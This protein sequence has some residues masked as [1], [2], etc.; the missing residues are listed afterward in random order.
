M[1]LQNSLM[2]RIRVSVEWTCERIV[3]AAK[4]AIFSRTQMLQNS[5]LTKYYTVAVLLANCRTCF[6]GGIDTAYFGVVPPSIDDYS[7]Q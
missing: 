7:N 3:T 5:P 4:F 2:S 1:V 6:Y